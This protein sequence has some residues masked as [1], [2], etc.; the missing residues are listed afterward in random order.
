MAIILSTHARAGLGEVSLL[1]TEASSL[2]LSTAGPADQTL[3]RQLHLGG[4][5]FRAACGS[6]SLMS[7][8][9]SRALSLS[10]RADKRSH[11]PGRCM[12]WETSLT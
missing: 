4:R 1:N 8:A 6:V 3:G 11:A 2:I 5:F 12:R 10:V 9:Q 7:A